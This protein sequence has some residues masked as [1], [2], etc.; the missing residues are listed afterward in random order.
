MASVRS[1]S[2]I[3]KSSANIS[4]RWS[5]LEEMYC[6]IAFDSETVWERRNGSCK[7]LL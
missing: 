5:Y 7:M 6:V 1:R 2:M 4:G 3:I